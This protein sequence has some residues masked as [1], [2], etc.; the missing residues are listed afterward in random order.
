MMARRLAAIGCLAILAACSSGPGR[1][2]D[3]RPYEERLL[4]ARAEKDVMFRLSDQSPLPEA[5]KVSFTGLPYYT[6]EPSMRVPAA[7]NT[8]TGREPLVIEL[9][10]S[11]GTKRRMRRVGTLD[12][13]LRGEA[14]SL[15]AF[16]D[17]D[18]RTNARLFV[19]FGDATNRDETYGG[20]R[21]I[22]LDRTP[23]G[24]YDL[25]FNLAY[26]PYCVF[27]IQFECPVPPRENRL[28]VAIRAGER[29]P[30]Q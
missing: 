17:V 8:E 12:F 11:W 28:D 24:L 26:H 5:D 16:A 27:N 14:H 1:P 30:A 23:T 15:T 2:V 7:L 21:Y 13:T 10:T 4:A 6:V 19:P 9:S 3:D 22:E 29:L 18:D 20:G 25:D